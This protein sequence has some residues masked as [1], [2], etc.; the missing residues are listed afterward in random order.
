MVGDI[1]VI[2]SYIYY[3]LFFRKYIFS[4][5]IYKLRV[6]FAR[7]CA[8]GMK[9]NVPKCSF[10]LKDILYLGYIITR[11]GIKPDPNKLQGTMYLGWPTTMPEYQALIVMV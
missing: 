8:T 3:I 5:H 9:V 4:K 2:K 7:L 11:D 10:G 1:E 6:V